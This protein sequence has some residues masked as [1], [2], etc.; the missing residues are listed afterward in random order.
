MPVAT[1]FSKSLKNQSLSE[2]SDHRSTSDLSL[3]MPEF[4]RNPL[5]RCV[6]MISYSTAILSLQLSAVAMAQSAPLSLAQ[7]AEET[8]ISADQIPIEPQAG[9]LESLSTEQPLGQTSTAE[10][11]REQNDEPDQFQSAAAD[12]ADRSAGTKASTLD[13][14]DQTPT[15]KLPQVQRSASIEP[16]NQEAEVSESASESSIQDPV[17]TSNQGG[18]LEDPESQ[19]QGIDPSLYLPELTDSETD[20]ETPTPVE[21]DKPPF[22]KRLYNRFFGDEI[23]DVNYIKV[24]TKKI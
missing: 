2:S 10:Q 3:L 15:A 22:Y 18:V 24:E 23:G 8:S 13:M 4:S 5:N 17:D 7:S 11:I 16:L 6:R 20:N 14:T 12:F 19:T 9:S 21:A 1:D